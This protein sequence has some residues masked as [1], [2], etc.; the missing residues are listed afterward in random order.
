MNDVQREAIR[1][2]LRPVIN[3]IFHETITD[4]RH[5]A[6]DE[7][8][9][10]TEPLFENLALGIKGVADDLIAEYKTQFRKGQASIRVGR[11]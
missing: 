9:S 6:E 1:E 10:G 5:P 3:N 11:R 7:D 4:P 2:A 8:Y